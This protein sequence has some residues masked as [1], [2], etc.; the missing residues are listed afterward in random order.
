M[1]GLSRLADIAFAWLVTVDN[2]PNLSTYRTQYEEQ[3]PSPRLRE[4]LLL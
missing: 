3:E 4:L 2:H 1:K